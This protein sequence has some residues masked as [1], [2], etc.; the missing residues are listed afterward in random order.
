MTVWEQTRRDELLAHLDAYSGM[1]CDAIG[2]AELIRFL[3]AELERA[4]DRIEKLE[5]RAERRL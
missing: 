4:Y 3:L 5:R 1:G 2:A